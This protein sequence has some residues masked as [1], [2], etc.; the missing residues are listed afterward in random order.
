M[1]N[2][3]SGKIKSTYRNSTVCMRTI[4]TAGIGAQNQNA[5]YYIAPNTYACMRSIVA[6]VTG[7]QNQNTA[8]YIAPNTY[9]YKNRD[10]SHTCL[11]WDNVQFPL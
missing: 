1:R 10:D 11:Q 6:T 9:V 2:L 8:Y 3:V 4:K 7:A 5:A